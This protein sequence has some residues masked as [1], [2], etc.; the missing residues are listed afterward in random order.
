M[1][2]LLDS[3]D[4]GIPRFESEVANRELMVDLD[5]GLGDFA[6]AMMPVLPDHRGGGRSHP[7]RGQQD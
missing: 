7:K 6:D 4:E 5:V 1:E 2:A 3:A